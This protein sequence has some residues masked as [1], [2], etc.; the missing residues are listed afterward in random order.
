[1]AEHNP[2]AN[3][4]KNA[5]TAAGQQAKKDLN[6]GAKKIGD[7]IRD[8][9]SN[10]SNNAGAENLKDR[11]ANLAQKATETAQEYADRMRDM[12]GEYAGRAKAEAERLYQTSQQKASEVAHYAEERYDEVSEMVRRNPAQA[13]GIAAGIGFLVGLILARR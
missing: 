12:G 1:M 8:T 4:M 9:A 2:N 10:L 7:D 11:G 13:L 5:A 6:E 3:D